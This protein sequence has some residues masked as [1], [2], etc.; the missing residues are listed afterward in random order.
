VDDLDDA[1]RDGFR[2][3]RAYLGELFP[4]ET[5]V[6]SYDQEYGCFSFARDQGGRLLLARAL[7]QGLGGRHLLKRL[8][9]V[10]AREAL[11]GVSR[12]TVVIVTPEDA[13]VEPE[14]A[15]D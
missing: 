15:R 6:E 1:E 8:K 3:V 13:F 7:L 11:R 14:T 2:I 4:N 5:L 9:D 12:G 10:K